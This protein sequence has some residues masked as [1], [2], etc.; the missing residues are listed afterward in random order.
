MENKKKKYRII[1]VVVIIIL[2]YLNYF[3]DEKTI[4][5]KEKIVETKGVEY[6]SEDY[7]VDAGKQ[8]DYIEKGETA[9]QGAKAK[10]K[11]MIL[12]GDNAFLD[13]ARNLA[14]N[15]N[16]FGLSPNGWSFKGEN[17]NYNKL[18]DEIESK[19]GI[20]VENK[21]KKISISG[22]EF[23]TNSKMDFIELY[24]D[25]TIENEKIRIVGDE[26]HYKDTDKIAILKNNIRL[27]LKSK[28]EK[29]QKDLAGDFKELRYDTKTKTITGDQNYTL[30]YGDAR[31]SAE[32]FFYRE[33]DES[34]KISKNVFI[35]V[36]GY[37][38]ELSRIEKD[39][40]VQKLQLVGPIKGASPERKFTSERG[41][42]N[43]E[44][45]ELELI[46]KV[47]VESVKGE[48]LD[49]DK[50]VYN[51][52]RE[53]IIASGNDRDVIYK[54][55]EEVFM[56]KEIN[57][58]SK[59][60]VLTINQDFSFKNKTQNGTGK[61][62]VYD[63]ITKEGTGTDITVY[64]GERVIWS[65][66]ILY[67]GIT[68]IVDFPVEYKVFNKNKTEEFNSEKGQYN[69]ATKEFV[70]D[71]AFKYVANGNLVEGIGLLYN[72]ESGNGNIKSQVKMINAEKGLDIKS[73]KVEIAN[74][75]IV[76]FMDNVDIKNKEYGTKVSK[77]Q[78][79]VKNEN[80]KIQEP[81]TIKSFDGKTTIKFVNPI[82]DVAK[83]I[84]YGD[85]FQGNG[86]NYVASSDKVQYKYK[87]EKIVLIKNAFIQ[88]KESTVKGERIEYNLKT[89]E[90]NIEGPYVAKNPQ[91]DLKGV[92]L[93]LN[94]TTGD[95]K[96][97]KINAVSTT[98]ESFESD[99]VSGNFNTTV[100]FIGNAK[101]RT[102]NKEKLIEYKGD[103]VKAHFKK[104]GS[105]YEVV[106]IE[107]VDNSM[108]SQ[109]NKTMYS[110][111]TDID[112]V[113]SIAVSPSRPKI[114]MVDQKK[115]DTTVEADKM[116]FYLNK[117]EV[118][119]IENVLII[120]EDKEKGK[121]VATAKRGLAKSKEKYVQLEENVVVDSPQYILY[122]D[123]A[124]YKTDSKKIKAYG[125]VKVDYKK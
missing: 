113:N 6:V 3:A 39:P 8:I 101:G 5:P 41:V 88:E 66:K 89:Q 22:K 15:S 1:G 86:E 115:G 105:T 62:L 80:I 87:E 116:E 17:I 50:V 61:T 42:Y 57:Y 27:S 7:I 65:P 43:I 21:E 55:A 125:D 119:L 76:T 35:D 103:T 122:A 72:S 90:S 67:N 120:S 111:Y 33:S 52:E 36:A 48:I 78:Y 104:K 56:S 77:A 60:K 46:G 106:R 108:I 37:H 112:L 85:D 32:N 69:L 99:K 4:T 58:S 71:S 24:K 51:S 30:N 121:T 74:G 96:G 59:S 49:A 81:V 94:N 92:N 9:F 20:L 44:T 14:L 97:G 79:F 28:D 11:D 13:K 70:S 54:T 38:I 18:A 45:K 31:L 114:V 82:I 63:D 100:D 12:S 109:E 19:T 117:D 16:V 84:M 75:E 98:K 53:D 95:V 102:Y 91:W 29:F 2:G 107:L 23:K 10:I 26:G 34:M 40:G 123:R 83:E 68:N 118:K 64:S 124:D 73:D 25:V 47:H 110:T 93:I